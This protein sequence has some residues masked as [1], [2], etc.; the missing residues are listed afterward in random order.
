MG[1]W[2]KYSIIPILAITRHGF[3]LATHDAFMDPSKK[4][5][6]KLHHAVGLQ[7]RCTATACWAR[8]HR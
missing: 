4:G 7:F 3:K 1:P 6:A 5:S 8:R 2:F